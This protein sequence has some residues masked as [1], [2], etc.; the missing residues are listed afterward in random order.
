MIEGKE[1]NVLDM[2][3]SYLGVK[4]I[5]LMENAGRAVAEV[6]SQ[7]FPSKKLLFLCGT[8]NNGGDGFVAARYLARSKP[9]IILAKPPQEIRTDIARRN[10]LRAK[11]KC[12]ILRPDSVD[13]EIEKAD[14]I[15]DA[16]LGVGFQGELKEPYRALFKRINASKKPVIAVDVPSGLGTRLAVKPTVTVTFHDKKT[17]MS[18]EN[19]GK[20]IVKDIG[21][22]KEAELFTGPG[23]FLYYPV[24]ESESHKGDNGRLLVIGGGPY[25]GAP[26]LAGMAAYRIG[27]DLVRIATPKKTYP[28]IA[29]YSPNFIVHS[30]GE[31]I[32][33]MDD[34]R[35]VL[36]LTGLVDAVIIGPGLGNSRKTKEIIREVVRNCSKS[37]VIDAD[38][39]EAVSE[40]LKVLGGHDGVITPHR[41]EFFQLTGC[42]L[43]DDMDEKLTRVKEYASKLK[44]TLLLKG[45]ID[46]ISDGK[47]TKM[48][49]TGNAGMTVGGTGDVLAGIVGGL[50]AKGMEPFNAARL[51]AF[52]SGYA[53]DLAFLEKSY[54]LLATDI[55]EKIPEVLKR[56]LVRPELKSS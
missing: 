48:N 9:V 46:I 26:T 12:R 40:N 24:P 32:L 54:G 33:T 18:K 17:G 31:D 13:M 53:G 30:L 38:G 35:S 56:L 20:I 45:K 19:S 3:A 7:L 49:R 10:F 2:N 43:S 28:I 52:V 22:P 27:V 21:I 5:Q 16:L 8:G 42:R 50:L 25:T 37:L 23:E 29:S 4:A 39:I 11:K 34:F 44:F 14:V 15:V 36:K 55:V 51:G 47:R 41:G 1:V 6:A